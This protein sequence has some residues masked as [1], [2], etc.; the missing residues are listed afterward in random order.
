MNPAITPL[1][2]R[3]RCTACSAETSSAVLEIAPVTN[4]WLLLDGYWFCADHV[5]AAPW[6]IA[7]D[8]ANNA[9]QVTMLRLAEAA[10]ERGSAVAERLGA[11]VEVSQ[12]AAR[13]E[14]LEGML[15]SERDAGALRTRIRNL[16]ARNEHERAADLDEQ[17]A[18]YATMRAQIEALRCGDLDAFHDGEL[19]PERA[20]AFRLHLATCAA[21]E[22]G[23]LSLMR[24]DVNL[25][26]MAD[27]GVRRRAV[28]DAAVAWVT[29]GG[30][31]AALTAAVNAME[32]DRG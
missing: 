15:G 14:G 5:T 8:R 24:L 28:F 17:S 3:I 1:P 10:D 25:A 13:C 20:A 12:L 4:G 23:L 29:A 6:I 16:R 26:G 11:V 30:T 32:D 22:A 18:T 9:H 27:V 21:C 2:T 7:L 31:L 19:S